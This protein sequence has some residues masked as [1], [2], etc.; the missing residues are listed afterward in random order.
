[1]RGS[2]Y[3]PR[4]SRVVGI[5][6]IAALVLPF[7]LNTPSAY[8][9]TTGQVQGVVFQDLNTNT[10]R[11]AFEPPAEGIEVTLRNAGDQVV[12]SAT[13]DVA[14]AYTFADV[15]AGSYTAVITVPVG[16]A[17]T[18]PITVPVTV[19]ADTTVTADFG[20]LRTSTATPPQSAYLWG[21]VINDLNGNG[22]A[23]PGEPGAAGVTVILYDEN[24]E[25][26]ASVVTDEN[27]FYDFGTLPVGKYK[28][29]FTPV[30][31]FFA[32]TPVEFELDLETE[33]L[34]TQI[35]GTRVLHKMLFPLLPYY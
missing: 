9:Q 13:S 28:V 8:A 29:A 33:S 12:G 5:A 17:A 15:E 7:C 23:D 21:F 18:S 26:V 16:F 31:G 30:G 27:G 24:D 1:M 11:D 20:V 35:F 34:T 22:I 3:L 2:P 14:G 19:V 10:V 32:T 4:W 6:V 25:E